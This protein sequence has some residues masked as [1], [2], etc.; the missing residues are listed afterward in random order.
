M[1][2][3]SGIRH[4]MGKRG[5]DVLSRPHRRPTPYPGR[6]H[7]SVT[8]PAQAKGPLDPSPAPTVAQGGGEEVGLGLLAARHDESA[9]LC[10]LVVEPCH[11]VRLG[12]AVVETVGGQ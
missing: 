8:E 5:T 7:S 6:P 3:Y 10:G 9:L 2:A 1:C 11:E 12:Y 4:A